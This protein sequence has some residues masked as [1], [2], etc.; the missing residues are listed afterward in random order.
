M[1]SSPGWFT[2]PGGSGRL[3]YW[4]GQQWTQ[5]L[6]DAPGGSTSDHYPAQQQSSRGP[7]LWV[8]LGV[9]LIVALIAGMIVVIRGLGS[10]G[11]VG[12]PNG[13]GPVSTAS[14]T[15]SGWDEQE[16]PPPSPTPSTNPSTV[17]VPCESAPVTALTPGASVVTAGGFTFTRPPNWSDFSSPVSQ[18]V[19][20]S[21]SVFRTVPDSTWMSTIEA[22]YAP[23]FDDE[24]TAA[25]TVLDCYFTSGSDHGHESYAVLNSEEITIDGQTG[26]WLKVRETNPE[27][28]GTYAIL[29]SV[30][31]DAGD[32]E[33][34]R[35]FWTT[36]YEGDPGAVEDAEMAF[37]SLKLAD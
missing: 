35:I 1:S 18:L 27:V 4:D 22:G 19:T 10:N 16:T 29:H 33:G 14:P 21:A 5:H 7:W 8:G 17:E 26:W 6:A 9:V 20:Q 2:D 15:I 3:R 25:R 34:M 30:A 24:K 32:P 13:G 12:L 23:G 11:P 31:L 36:G 37:Q 28:P